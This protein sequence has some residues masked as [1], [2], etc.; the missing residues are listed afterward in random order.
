MQLKDLHA[1]ESYGS[2]ESTIIITNKPI[3]MKALSTGIGILKCL[4]VV[5][6]SRKLWVRG[7][8]HLQS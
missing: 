1:Q 4:T 7:V 6:L 3:Y 8:I 5:F 2:I